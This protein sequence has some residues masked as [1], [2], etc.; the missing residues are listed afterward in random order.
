MPASTIAP[1]QHQRNGSF[2]HAAHKKR[3]SGGARPILM[4]KNTSS[5][6]LYRKAQGGSSSHHADEEDMSSTFQ[7]FCATCDTLIVVPNASILYCSEACRRKDSSLAPPQ[8]PNRIA[9]DDVARQEPDLIPPLSPTEIKRSSFLPTSKDSAISLN[10][11]AETITEAPNS[12]STTG[13]TMTSAVSG[14]ITS[15]TQSRSDVNLANETCG[16]RQSVAPSLSCSVN[17][18]ASSVPFTPISRSLGSTRYPATK[19]IE[20]VT[21][22]AS[23]ETDPFV[24]NGETLT[25]EDSG[26]T[27][28]ALLEPLDDVEDDADDLF[29]P[30]RTAGV[31][32][33]QASSSLKRLLNG[34]NR[35]TAK[36]R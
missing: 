35:R 8:S 3:N 27:H 36:E 29:I 19:S 16:R 21:P 7:Q 4:K 6:Q 24:T 9:V 11:A 13:S 23:C 28:K 12:R 25:S 1:M 15:L 26:R 22:T 34:D 30:S 14:N 10:E 18:F 17:S 31:S 33:G 32:S 2:S 20:L 5:K